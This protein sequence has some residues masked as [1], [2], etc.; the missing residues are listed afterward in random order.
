MAH[1]CRL[2]L[3]IHDSLLCIG[4]SAAA[5]RLVQTFPD[6][7]IGEEW[8]E[9]GE[10]QRLEAHLASSG[11]DTSIARTMLRQL[12]SRQLAHG[13]TLLFSHPAS[14]GIPA[15]RGS[16]NRWGFTFTAQEAL[17]EQ[18]RTRM[19]SFLESFGIGRV[20]CFVDDSPS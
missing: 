14:E 4:Y 1:I 18:L 19:I 11:T 15:F 12:R 8:F 20:E 6:A 17:P 13:P 9:T 16:F 2:T 10:Y 3:E 7:V 5:E